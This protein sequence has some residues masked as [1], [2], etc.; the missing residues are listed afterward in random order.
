M[1]AVRLLNGYE[2][3]H[4]HA[5]PRRFPENLTGAGGACVAALVASLAAK[6]TWRDLL[7]DAR[8]SRLPL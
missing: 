3:A 2:E 7:R 1:D 6:R 4:V 5:R 8:P